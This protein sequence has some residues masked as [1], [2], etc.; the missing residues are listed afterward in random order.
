LVC[1]L[2]V[3]ISCSDRRDDGARQV[4]RI[5]PSG[6]EYSAA[7]DST[8]SPDTSSSPRGVVTQYYDAIRSGNYGIAYSLWSDSGRASG[9]TLDAFTSGYAQTV[10]VRA[11]FSDSVTVEGAAGSQFATVPVIIDAVTR[12]G[13]KQRFTGTYTLRRAMVDG[14][15]PEQRRW[16]IYSARLRTR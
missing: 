13:T 14:A 16:R 6:I 2:F 9:Q 5:S 15:T 4:V 10:D 12:D 7:P 3:V 8:I 11:T 1:A